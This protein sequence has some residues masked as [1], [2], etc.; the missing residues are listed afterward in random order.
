MDFFK[1]IDN[2]AY[3]GLRFEA[4]RSPGLADAMRGVDFVGSFGW[5]ALLALLALPWRR[6][7]VWRRRAVTMFVIAAVGFASMELVRNVA[8]R[9]RPE[10]AAALVGGAMGKSFP[11]LPAFAFP[12]AAVL[13]ATAWL[14][15]I[16]P[17]R[18][19]PKLLFGAVA[20]AVGL[21]AFSQLLLG[22]GF[23][24]DVLTGLAGGLGFALLARAWA[25]RTPAL[26]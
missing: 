18:A 20:V 2:G 12:L 11:N 21:V 5:I 24:S 25:A 23:L 19:R 16:E 22:L 1:G 6:G 10:D 26:Q 4:G 7:G 17:T 13:G 8:D 15:V 14:S 9:R 3:A